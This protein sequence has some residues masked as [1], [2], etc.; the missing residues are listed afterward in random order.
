MKINSKKKK[1]CKSFSKYCPYYVQIYISSYEHITLQQ[2]Y[3]VI[4]LTQAFSRATQ[5]MEASLK[6]YRNIIYSILR[7]FSIPDLIPYQFYQL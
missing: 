6:L 5:K 3:K 4:G 7:K 2:I 1:Y